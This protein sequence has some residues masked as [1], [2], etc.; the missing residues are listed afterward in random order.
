MKFKALLIFAFISIKIFSVETQV[1]SFCDGRPDI[2]RVDYYLGKDGTMPDYESK[3][4]FNKVCAIMLKK[5]NHN[6]LISDMELTS[7]YF[8]ERE[9][10]V[11]L[12]LKRSIYEASY[13]RDKRLLPLILGIYDERIKKNKNYKCDEY[14]YGIKYD[15]TGLADE[16]FKKYKPKYRDKNP[17]RDVQ[18]DFQSLFY[19]KDETFFKIKNELVM[20]ADHNGYFTLNLYERAGAKVEASHGKFYIRNRL[21]KIFKRYFYYLKCNELSLNTLIATYGY[22]L[23]IY[24]H[25]SSMLHLFTEYYLSGEFGE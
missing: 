15:T 10:Y 20:K 23:D 2:P 4:Q 11:N 24:A 5:Q 14:I 3:N 17:F 18:K 8:V 25:R 9:S 16:L 12:K 7:Y 1:L 22:P 13:R 6:K 19:F 21:N